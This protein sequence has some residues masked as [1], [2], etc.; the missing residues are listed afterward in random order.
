MLRGEGCGYQ[1][2]EGVLLRMGTARF[3]D[4]TRQK[5]GE[6]Q[7]LYAQLSWREELW[8]RLFVPASACVGQRAGGVASL[9]MHQQAEGIVE[10]RPI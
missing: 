9:K 4:H 2:I 1:L 6:A 7:N 8:M 10:T 5:I 3:I